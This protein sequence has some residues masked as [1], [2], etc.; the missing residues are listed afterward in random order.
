MT[1]PYRS[2]AYKIIHWNF[3]YVHLDSEIKT[4]NRV[5]N[6]I[7]RRVRHWISDRCAQCVSASNSITMWL[8]AV[9]AI[10]GIVSLLSAFWGLDT[11]SDIAAI[12]AKATVRSY[13]VTLKLGKLAK[14][15]TK[16]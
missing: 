13:G 1:G 7:F 10:T 11:V 16:R 12:A 14:L 5:V 4:E 3:Q 6:P 15:L 8:A 9:W 2:P